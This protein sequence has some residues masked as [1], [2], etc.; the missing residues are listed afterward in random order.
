MKP[1]RVQLSR[2]KDWKMPANTVKIDRTTKWGNPFKPG[3][4]D[5]Y[6]PGI[7]TSTADCVRAF[8]QFAEASLAQD[9]NK[10][11]ELSGKNLACWCPLDQPCHGEVL[12]ELA[13]AGK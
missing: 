12:L 2:R 6:R 13:N 5:P 7:M 9:A 11:A 1:V 10:Y 8:R 3:E 4:P